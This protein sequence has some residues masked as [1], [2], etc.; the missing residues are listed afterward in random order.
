[1][2][3]VTRLKYAWTNSK[4]LRLERVTSA[5]YVEYT[6]SQGKF[7]RKKAGTTK[8]QAVDVL[9]KLEGDVLNEK[10]GLP[11]ER[12]N[13]VRCH[14]LRVRYLKVLKP[15]AA[16]RHHECVE[17]H[18]LSMLTEMKAI[19]VQDITHERVERYLAELDEKG[20]S[21]R[22]VN[23]YLSNLKAMLNW[24]VRARILL[25]NPITSVAKRSEHI[26]H[27]ARR[28]LSDAE[29]ARL[30]AAAAD[31]PQRRSNRAY[32]GGEIE[33][34]VVANLEY[35]ARRNILVYK[36]L[37]LTGLRLNELRLLRWAD[38]DLDAGTLTTQPWWAGNKNGKQEVLPLAPSLVKELKEW[39]GDHKEI[40]EPVIHIPKQFLRTFDD[41]L[42]AAGIA[43]RV[44]LDDNGKPIPFNML[45]KPVVTPTKWVIDKRD[46]QG[47]VIDLHALRHTFG[48]RLVANGVDIKTAQSLMRHSTPNLTLSIYVHKDNQ[49][50]AA[51][52]AALPEI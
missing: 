2:G 43:K 46:A 9:R 23:H 39:R 22:T 16:K 15:R 11:T 28:A 47:R 37:V 44:P 27:H 42:L 52:V 51:A 48:T 10:N 33:P 18:L 34:D 31:G 40:T 19:T 8:E 50:M 4:G 36:I 12:A 35:L 41:D 20:L 25:Y 3:R 45:G 6:D 1:M 26:K 17:Q 49:R 13:A 7:Q 21:A 30:L 38:V 24:A 32:K 5:W 14:D 29:L